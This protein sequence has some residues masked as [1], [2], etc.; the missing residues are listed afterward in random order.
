MSLGGL[1]RPS[2]PPVSAWDGGTSRRRARRRGRGHKGRSAAAPIGHQAATTGGVLQALGRH[3]DWLER[4][5][6]GA[7]HCRGVVDD[8]TIVVNG[9]PRC[10]PPTGVSA[11]VRLIVRKSARERL[12]MRSGAAQSWA[13]CRPGAGRRPPDGL[14]AGVGADPA[15]SNGRCHVLLRK[16]SATSAIGW[17]SSHAWYAC[18]RRSFGSG[19][20]MP[21]SSRSGNR[22]QVDRG[23]KKIGQGILAWIDGLAVSH[24]FAGRVANIREYDDRAG[25]AHVVPRRRRTVGRRR[26]VAEC[27]VDRAS[28]CG[29]PHPQPAATS[30]AR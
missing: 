4:A 21:A 17:P 12:D 22:S 19:C 13:R 23:V 28:T 30:S 29:R 10:E 14:V 15:I 18:S 24:E 5:P 7:S 1:R 3:E 16:V 6:A 8:H 26:L 20:A 27:E 2:D 11:R 25:V 9:Y